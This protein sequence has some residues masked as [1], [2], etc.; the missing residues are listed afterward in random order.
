MDKP[1]KTRC[2]ECGAECICDEVDIGVGMQQGPP[3]CPDCG[4]DSQSDI[5]DFMKKFKDKKL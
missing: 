3:Y 4:W 5:P 1:K 2:P